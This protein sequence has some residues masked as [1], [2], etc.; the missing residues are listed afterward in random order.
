MCMTKFESVNKDINKWDYI[1]RNKTIVKKDKKKK[2]RKPLPFFIDF[3]ILPKKGLVQIFIP[4]KFFNH[5]I[6]LLLLL[7]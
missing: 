1:G 2:K 7:L 4:N 5:E 6:F 3:Q